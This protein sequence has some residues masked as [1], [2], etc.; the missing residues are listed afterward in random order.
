MKIWVDNDACPRVI[1]DIIFKAARRLKLEV[2]MVANRATVAHNAS[3]IKIITVPAGADIADK[4]IIDQVTPLDVVITADI[5]LAD[6]VVTKGSV[7]INPRGYLYTEANIK[8]RLSVRDL[9]T[10]LRDEG[11]IRGGGPPQFGQKDR[12]NFA[13]S[14][15]RT[16]T[17]LQNKVKASAT[18]PGP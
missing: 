4:Y 15:D 14:L 13:N 2:Y 18:K 5:P 6:A 16:L 17:K 12:E 1:K 7:A 10:E 9:M 11:T 3:F 8:E